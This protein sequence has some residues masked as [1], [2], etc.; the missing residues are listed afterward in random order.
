M[1]TY[2]GHH[3]AVRDIQFNTNGKRFLSCS[4]DRYIRLWDTES[5]TVLQTFTNR[6]VPYV[7]QFYPKNDNYFVTGCS[8]NKIVAYDCTTGLMHQE[9]NH[10]LAPVNTITFVEPEEKGAAM[11]MVTSSD[12]KKVLVWEWD[13]GVPIKYISDPTMHS[14]PSIA[15]HPN[16]AYLACSALDNCIRVYQ[17]GGG[18][19]NGRFAIQKKKK[20]EGHRVAGYSCDLSFSPDGRFLCS[21]DGEGRLFFWEWKR[22]RLLQKYRA[23][24]GG[25]PTVGC[26]WHP[27]M[28]SVVFTCG[29]DGVIKMWE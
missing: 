28:P 18:G 16:G 12:D 13:I 9:Y 11:I 24:D 7:L 3:A 15:L 1:R 17:A 26:V 22:G 27:I 29:W 6:R 2:N 8:D 4:F 23:H 25:K 19:N 5:G 14:M 20:F 21:G 10:H